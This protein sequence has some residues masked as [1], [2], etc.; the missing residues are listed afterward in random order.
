[1]LEVRTSF[2]NLDEPASIQKVL[3]VKNAMA[4]GRL[5]ENLQTLWPQVSCEFA[6]DSTPRSM[7]VSVIPS[8]IM[9]PIFQTNEGA[10]SVPEVDV[11]Y[12]WKVEQVFLACLYLSFSACF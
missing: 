1:M 9:A 2:V 8:L 5:L 3:L 12:S 10:G 7:D 11:Q 6:P 4:S